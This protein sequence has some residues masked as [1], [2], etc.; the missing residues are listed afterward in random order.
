MQPQSPL[1]QQQPQV[2]TP[3]QFPQTTPAVNPIVL[4]TQQQLQQAQQMAAQAAS[5]V[6]SDTSAVKEGYKTSEFWLHL[7]YQLANWAITL[8]LHSMDQRLVGVTTSLVGLLGYLTSRTVVKS[9][10]N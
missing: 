9:S 4:P 3:A 1:Q 10:S 7:A 6:K 8:N 5:L 2:V